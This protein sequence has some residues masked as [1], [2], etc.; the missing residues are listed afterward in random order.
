[1]H[2]NFLSTRAVAC[3]QPEN[4]QL[5]LEM[6]SLLPARQIRS[7]LLGGVPVQREQRIAHP[8]RRRAVRVRR[9][10]RQALAAH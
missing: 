1:M 2:T 7:R 4:R 6:R 9:A 3:L 10:V 8:P 5:A